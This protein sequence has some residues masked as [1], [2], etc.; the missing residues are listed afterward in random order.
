MEGSIG[1]KKCVLPL[2]LAALC[3]GTLF[4]AMAEDDD[5]GMPPP[6]PQER[7]DFRN[8]RQEMLKSAMTAKEYG[9]YNKL[10]DDLLKAAGINPN[11]TRETSGARQNVSSTVLKAKTSAMKAIA[12][13]A[14]A[15]L[16]KELP[17]QQAKKM[18]M[19]EKT[20]AL[21]EL[22]RQRELLQNPESYLENLRKQ[23]EFRRPPE[24]NNNTDR[25]RHSSSSE[26]RKRR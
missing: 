6:R 21:A 5:G 2:L 17:E 25:T 7:P 20:A 19:A 13:A 1:M 4:A 15:R 9:D 10:R 12:D 26:R 22:E 16:W 14:S 24:H 3:G 8:R 23:Y 11:A 18:K